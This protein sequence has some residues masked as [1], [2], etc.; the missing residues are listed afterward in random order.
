M[1]PAAGSTAVQ[2]RRLQR[3]ISAPLPL[4]GLP[5]RPGGSVQGLPMTRGGPVD[6]EQCPGHLMRL[7]L[8]SNTN[9]DSAPL[10]LTKGAGCQSRY[11]LSGNC[12]IVL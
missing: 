8:L 12:M 9:N 3:K 7:S 6:G 2:L 1:W 4:Q 10:P 11:N 5:Q